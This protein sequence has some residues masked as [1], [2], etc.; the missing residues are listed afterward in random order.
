[1]PVAD[2]SAYSLAKGEYSPAAEDRCCK[3]AISERRSTLVFR[4][5]VSLLIAVLLVSMIAKDLGGKATYRV[6]FRYNI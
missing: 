2:S 6:L 4:C 3:C 5:H 1:M